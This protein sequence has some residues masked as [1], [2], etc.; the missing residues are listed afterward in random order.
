MSHVNLES[1]LVIKPI[2]GGNKESLFPGAPS[3]IDSANY[4]ENFKSDPSE[5]LMPACILNPPIDPVVMIV[6]IFKKLRFG[7]IHFS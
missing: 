1:I 7:M 6:Q 3:D 5:N 4:F 2:V